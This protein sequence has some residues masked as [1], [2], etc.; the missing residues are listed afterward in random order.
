MV[1][2]QKKK[3]S[4][5]VTDENVFSSFDDYEPSVTWSVFVFWILP[6]LAIA[7]MSRFLVDPHAAIGFGLGKEV[8]ETPHKPVIK[9]Q[10]PSTVPTAPTTPTIQP[11]PQ[12]PKKKSTPVP[13][14]A[15]DKPSSYI[16]AV[17]AIDRRRLNWEETDASAMGAYASAAT[18]KPKASTTTSSTS[19]KPKARPDKPIRGASSDPVRSQLLARIDEL[20]DIHEVCS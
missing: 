15:A 13:T 7:C 5:E 3:R 9:P 11:T 14:L 12:R 17:Q 1:D 18:D 20:R 10:P 6:I 2:Q 4:V 19:T 16:E 8:D